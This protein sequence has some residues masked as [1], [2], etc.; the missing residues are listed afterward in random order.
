MHRARAT[1]GRQDEPAYLRSETLR[2]LKEQET[3]TGGSTT[4]L[5]SHPN[6][7]GLPVCFICTRP[8]LG[9]MARAAGKNLHGDCLS[10][11]TCGNSLRN[12]GHHFIEDKFY[13]DIHGTQRKAGGR[14]GMDP[15]I[16]V[17]SS[18]TAAQPVHLQDSPRAA[19]HPQIN[20]PLSVSPAPSAG[21]KTVTTH[22]HTPKTQGILS[23][24]QRGVPNA[25]FGADLSKTVSYGAGGVG[26]GGTHYDPNRL[27]PAPSQFSQ[28]S[29]TQQA[30]PPVPSNPPPGHDTSRVPDSVRSA[31]SPRRSGRVPRG[32]QWP[33][34][35]APPTNRYW[36]IDPAEALK[37]EKLNYGE[38]LAA[39]I[40]EVEQTKE[41]EPPKKI[42]TNKKGAGRN[43][44]RRASNIS[45]EQVKEAFEEHRKKAEL[46]KEAEL[47]IEPPKIQDG[48]HWTV[49]HSPRSP[50]PAKVTSEAVEEANGVVKP[51][52]SYATPKPIAISKTSS[53][54]PFR[55][56]EA[57]EKP[58]YSSVGLTAD[59]S[60][61]LDR[62]DRQ[63]RVDRQQDRSTNLNPSNHQDRVD[64]TDRPEDR[65]YHTDRADRQDR[66]QDRS[67][68]LDRPDR[69]DHL[70]R[71]DRKQDNLD[72]LDRADRQESLAHQQNVSTNLDRLD[73][74]QDRP[75]NLDR[76]QDHSY[77]LD[78]ADRLDRQQSRVEHLDR[79]D[80]TDRADRQQDHS[81]NLG[82]VDRQERLDLT[83]REDRPDRQQNRSTN[84]D[85]PDRLDRPPPTIAAP[86]P[87]PRSPQHSP[88][89]QSSYIVRASDANI[90]TSTNLQ[91]TVT[92]Q[93]TGLAPPHPDTIDQSTS[94]IPTIRLNRKTV[95]TVAI[96]NVATSPVDHNK[97]MDQVGRPSPRPWVPSPGVKIHEPNEPFRAETTLG[98]A[99]SQGVRKD[100][101]H[102]KKVDF[103]KTSPTVIP[104]WK[105]SAD[106]ID[107]SDILT[108][109]SKEDDSFLKAAT[110]DGDESEMIDNEDIDIEEEILEGLEGAEPLKMIRVVGKGEGGEAE[111]Q[112]RQRAMELLDDDAQ[113]ERDLMIVAALNERLQGLREMEDDDR[114]RA[115]ECIARH[116]SE[117][118]QTQTQLST[119]LESAI[120]YLQNL[121]PA[122]DPLLDTPSSPSIAGDR[123][124]ELR[125]KV[126]E[127]LEQ[128]PIL[129]SA[130]PPPPPERK[131]FPFQSYQPSERS[132]VGSTEPVT[133][134]LHDVLDE[135]YSIR[136]KPS[137]VTDTAE[138]SRNFLAARLGQV[139][140]DDDGKQGSSNYSKTSFE[141]TT[142]ENRP[143]GGLDRAAGDFRG[144]GHLT[145]TTTTTQQQ[146]GGRIPYCEACK[147]QIR[148]AFVLA[149]G[150]S[151]CPEHFVCANSSCR[152]R[153][154][155]CG[156]VEE[157][158]QK[159]CESCFEQHIAPRCA[160]CSKPIIS[161]CLNAL[162]KKWHPT[163]FTCAHCQKPFGNSAF[164][165]E[166]G[167]PYCE[168]DWN[169]LFT[170]KCVSCRYPIEAGDRWVEALGN[171]FH[172]NCFTCA[173]CN[174]NLE[175]ESFFAK[176]GQ[177]FCRLHA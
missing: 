114:V 82:R 9:V 45:K 88:L 149:T 35:Q 165:L 148:G 23:P 54:K 134:S 72:H 168:Q 13:C 151:W 17:K 138:D 31:V 97:L 153:L 98:S 79:V 104:E 96:N 167:L 150:K 29:R 152:R 115:I 170:T 91:T 85:R 26:P 160:K 74:Q 128:L 142:T 47:K 146:N 108:E 66:Q 92:R 86:I 132:T 65:V 27:S 50:S 11:A 37:K 16:F 103:S 163:C 8:I 60:T 28:T 116:Q 53:P 95:P 171:A 10:C 19:Y 133:Q 64:Q 111:K 158:G 71:L 39:L 135:F 77:H 48:I 30:P 38:D 122:E 43:N 109:C 6:P 162:Q 176:N 173:R 89:Q 93:Y 124:M 18:P 99:H 140:I 46:K 156:F 118:E 41:K 2:L 127:D 112:W 81:A 110:Y 87:L 56:G 57:V 24:A 166:Q 141:R 70:D 40:R 80:R 15:N 32:H 22:Y 73:I 107:E 75:T 68:N 36:Q 69:A 169:A 175:G 102:F 44:A 157:D 147:N 58:H 67:T 49:I 125:K 34:P 143:Q 21:S 78:R 129:G 130:A 7:S 145:T 101:K 51:I 119:L 59:R 83:D 164:Y 174:H 137:G 155:E 113:T 62:P 126:L 154:L 94:P 42:I 12:V 5:S 90:T 100:P 177:P 14:P 61:N 33:P 25:A 121:R 139:M 172:S 55:S 136:R 84:L 4:T 123:V 105:D 3:P 106:I 117:L 159:F 144:T 76:Q 161:D 1:A 20:R 120:V 63:D 52:P 131:V